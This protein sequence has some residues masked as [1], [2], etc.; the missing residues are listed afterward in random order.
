M[1]E[2]STSADV[3]ND[4][5]LDKFKVSKNKYIKNLFNTILNP[6]F[7]MKNIPS[8]GQFGIYIK[9]YI[10]SKNF[11]LRICRPHLGE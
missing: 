2:T 3:V 7:R 4:R 5:F 6:R 11:P 9:I 1:F 10:L 8:S